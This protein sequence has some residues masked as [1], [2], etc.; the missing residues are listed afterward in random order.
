MSAILTMD[1][2]S[3]K[4]YTMSKSFSIDTYNE[5]NKIEI[6]EDADV[7]K[8]IVRTKAA[9]A[10]ELAQDC[11]DKRNYDLA[12]N[13]L[14]AMELDCDKYKDDVMFRQMKENLSKQKE[15]VKNEK[16][17]RGNVMNMKAYAMNS[18]NCYANQ[19][20][21]PL[22]AKGMFQNQSRIARSSKMSIIKARV[23]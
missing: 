16:E 15:M 21:S 12:E 14:S 6:H 3:G 19:E 8:H 5:S 13:M 20:S 1:N 2:L 9:E 10:I 22:M 7:K 11:C 4:Q 23:S 18:R 17:G